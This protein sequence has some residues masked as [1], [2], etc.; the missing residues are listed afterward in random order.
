[1]ALPHPAASD[2]LG[3]RRKSDPFSDA[4][5]ALLV[6]VFEMIAEPAPP[7]EPT[8]SPDPI[9]V[10]INAAHAML[11]EVTSAEEVAELSGR[12]LAACRVNQE[13]QRK[14]ADDAGEELAAAIALV[15]EV[16]GSL[17][18][19]QKHLKTTLDDSAR[20]F[21]ALREVTD[22]RDLK[23]RLTREIGG[24]KQLAAER[25]RS[26]RMEVSAFER[27]IATLEE[28]LAETKTEATQDAL[29][30][31]ANRR[32]VEATFRRW[33][34][35]RRAFVAA[36]LD[37]DDFKGVND[38][39][40]HAAGDAVLQLVAK[41]LRAAVRS[42]DL[43]ARLGGDEFVVMILDMTLPQAENRARNVL[44]TLS[45]STIP[46]D[47]RSVTITASAGVSELSPGDTLASL[48]ERADQALYESKGHGKNCVRSRTAPYL[49]DLRRR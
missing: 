20:R 28:Q 29:T 40:G 30:G 18:G 39:Y 22:I 3:L 17:V 24:L 34:V 31:L 8:A 6:G 41:T 14:Q 48:L 10:E 15:R 32:G 49:R 33:Q 23:L 26:R 42:G 9:R 25:D 47:D 7:R 19:E 36:V 2:I 46:S 45:Q 21:E 5:H 38:T 12:V 11:Q 1:M 4:L 35:E 37:I 44:Q 43:V 13:R 16:M 27:R